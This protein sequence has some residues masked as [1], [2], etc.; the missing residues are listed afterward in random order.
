MI[1]L[2]QAYIGQVYYLDRLIGSDHDRLRQLGF[3]DEV[4]I[5]LVTISRELATVRLGKTAGK[6]IS[7]DDDA[8]PRQL[9]LTLDL[10]QQIFVKN[11]RTQAHAASTSPVL[12]LSDLSVGQTG[13]V[14]SL[15]AEGELKRRLMDMGITRGTAILLYKRA[16]MGDPLELHLRGYSLSLRKQDAEKIRVQV[17][18]DGI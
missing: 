13:I 6:S 12:G 7:T 16:P 5:R 11:S 1:S 14:Q 2:D 10:L 8:K 3:V 4:A 17:D 18:S 15:A 9:D